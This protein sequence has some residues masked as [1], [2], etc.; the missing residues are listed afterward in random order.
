MLDVSVS[1]DRYKFLGY[2]FLTWLWFLIE[3]DQLP[4]GLAQKQ[5]DGYRQ[6]PTGS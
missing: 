3:K 6:T 5:K 1:Y 4:W 2:E